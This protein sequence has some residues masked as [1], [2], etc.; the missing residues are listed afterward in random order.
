MNKKN[1][2][3]TTKENINWSSSF[4]I[5]SL[6]FKP[7]R[8]QWYKMSAKFNERA[9]A[10]NTDTMNIITEIKKNNRKK[11]I[12]QYHIYGDRLIAYSRGH[13][14]SRVELSY[15]FRDSSTCCVIL[16][17]FFY[18]WT[19]IQSRLCHKIDVQKKNIL[20]YV[21]SFS[22]FAFLSLP[23]LCFNFRSKWNVGD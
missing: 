5:S 9:G 1:E 10:R 17:T 22:L 16:W 12:I 7:T 8:S 6:I 13:T 11:R 15:R 2:K 14:V 18:F 20:F 19:K 23:S 4:F 21:C 3:N